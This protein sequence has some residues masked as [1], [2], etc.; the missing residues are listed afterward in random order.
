M[1]GTYKNLTNPNPSTLQARVER[2]LEWMRR[3]MREAEELKQRDMQERMLEVESLRSIID[4]LEER[5]AQGQSQWD[6]D[7]RPSMPIE[8]PIA[9]LNPCPLDPI[10][11]FKPFY[12]RP[13]I[14]Y[15]H[16]SVSA[17]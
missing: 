12:L 11:H 9:I 1:D 13:P 17:E 15:P 2:D 10:G 3:E 7:P 4:G 6:A 8:A 16:R 5:K 14:L